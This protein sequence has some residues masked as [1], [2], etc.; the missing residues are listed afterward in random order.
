MIMPTWL[1]ILL[2]FWFGGVF[3]FGL[4]I[5]VLARMN[6]IEIKIGKET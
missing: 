3:G 2:A 5:V 6:H 1:G 4:A